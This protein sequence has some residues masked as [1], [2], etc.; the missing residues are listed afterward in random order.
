[1]NNLNQVKSSLKN[2]LEVSEK[3]PNLRRVNKVAGKPN[4][5]RKGK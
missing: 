5:G 1:M 2:H 4:F 3:K